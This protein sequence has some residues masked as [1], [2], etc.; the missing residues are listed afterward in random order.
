VFRP[1]LDPIERTTIGSWTARFVPATKPIAWSSA[2]KLV[3][4]R[5]DWEREWTRLEQS[6]AGDTLEVLKRDRSGDVVATTISLS[7][8]P[9]DVVLKR[10][11]EKSGIGRWFRQSKARRAWD[12]A[13]TLRA[14]NVPVEPPLV[15][16]EKRGESVA[17]YERVPGPTLENVNLDALDP[18]ARRTLFHR[19]GRLLR[20]I[21]NRKLA[22]TDAKS[23]NW[24]VFADPA[25]GPRP[26]LIDAYGIRWLNPWL[27]LF[28]LHR[29]L[30]AMKNHPQ[31][32]P[33]DSLAICQG[34][35]PYAEFAVEEGTKET[36]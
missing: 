6:I 5:Q 22:H 9:V 1:K 4:S 16:F 3:L 29:L 18:A 12:K 10:P 8:R 23:S 11:T 7:G 20:R 36:L 30:R 35:A 24:I 19:C 26:V 33:A 17:I 14:I 2:S 15:L 31:Y 28:G 34:F 25:M 27:Q 21:E 32:T 13:L